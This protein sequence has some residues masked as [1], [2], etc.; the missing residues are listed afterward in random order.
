MTL[1]TPQAILLCATFA[2][3]FWYGANSYVE[4]KQ[5]EEKANN[6]RASYS[7]REA[8]WAA[9]RTNDMVSLFA[10][11]TKPIEDFGCPVD[12]LYQKVKG[13]NGKIV[14]KRIC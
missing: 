1:T 7:E 5:I 6:V 2:G 14:S 3:C 10:S 13:K 8:Y 12:G 4:G 9:K 11:K